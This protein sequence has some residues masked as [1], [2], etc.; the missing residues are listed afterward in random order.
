ML[1]IVR[2]HDKDAIAHDP[3]HMCDVIVLEGQLWLCPIC[4]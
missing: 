1:K 2:W 4:M 3:L